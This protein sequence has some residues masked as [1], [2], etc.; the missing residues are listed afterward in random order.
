MLV[1]FNSLDKYTKNQY[2]FYYFGFIFIYS[3]KGKKTK[4]YENNLIYDITIASI[5]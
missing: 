2:K 5:N 3:D 4:Q 1:K